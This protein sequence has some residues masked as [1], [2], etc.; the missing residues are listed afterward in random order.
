MTTY[1]TTSGSVRGDCGHHHRTLSGADRC[2]QRDMDGCASQGG[3]SDRR[4]VAIDGEGCEREL[5]AEEQRL[6][7]D[8]W[9]ER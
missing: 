8:C 4:I 7:E 9:G 2:L 1:Y 5:S 3:Y 6:L